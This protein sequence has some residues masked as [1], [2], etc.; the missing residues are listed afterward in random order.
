M[1]LEVGKCYELVSD[2]KSKRFRVIKKLPDNHLIIRDCESGEEEEFYT[3]TAKG[4]FSEDWSVKEID[5][6]ECDGKPSI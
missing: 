3:E 6:E 1:K 2:G 4:G 5:C